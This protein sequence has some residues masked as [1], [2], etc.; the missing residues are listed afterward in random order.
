MAKQKKTASSRS[1]GAQRSTSSQPETKKKKAASRKAPRKTASQADTTSQDNPSPQAIVGIGASAGGLTTLKRFFANVAADTGLAYVVVMH[2]SPEYKSHLAEL[3]QPH[4]P[5]PVQQVTQTTPL[6]PNRV[7]VI[8]PGANLNTIDTHLRLTKLEPRR[9]ERAPIDYFFRTLAQTHDGNSIAVVLTGSGSDGTL[10]IRDIKASGGVALAQDPNDAEFGDMPQSA[11]S[12][13]LVDMVLP[14]EDIP[15]AIIRFAKTDP[16]VPALREGEEPDAVVRQQLQKIFTLLKSRTSR[17]FSRYKR[18]TIL[19]RI[20]RR[21]QLNQIEELH[22]YL[23]LLRKNQTEVRT[24]ADDLLITV[25]NFFRDPEVHKRLKD[26]IIPQLFRRKSPD[27]DIR[28]WSVGCA[29]GEEAYTLAML[30]LEEASQHESIPRLQVFASDLHER[31]LA[32]AR[33]GIYPGDIATDV[34]PERLKRFFVKENGHYRMR[35][36]VREMVVFAPHNLLADP[37]FS[38]IDLICCRNLMIYLQRG[39]QRNVIDLFHYAIRGEGFLVL[40]SAETLDS[41]DLFRVEDKKCCIYRKRNITPPEPRLPVFPFLATTAGDPVEQVP[42]TEAVGS[43]RAIHQRMLQQ[44][45]PPSAL[46]NTEDRV[47]HLSELAGRFFLHPG[48]EPTTNIYKLVRPELRL[49]LRSVMQESREAGGTTRSTPISV[50]FNGDTSV[51]LMRAIPARSQQDT[52]CTLVIFEEREPRAFTDR[53][54]TENDHD[55]ADHSDGR[56]GDRELEAE[57]ELTRQRLQSLVEEYETSQEEMKA[58]NEEM[59]SANEELR[60][61]MEELETSKEELQ[62]MNE[63]LQTVNQ[64][65]R[66]RV[67]ELAQLSSDLNNLFAATDIATLYLDKD[68]RILRLTPKVH[69]L[70]S[71]QL[72]DRGRPISDFTHRFG[73]EDLVADAQR[74]IDKLIPIDRELQDDQGRWHMTRVLPYRSDE[75]RIEGVVITFVDITERKRSEDETREAKAYAESIVDTLHEPLLVLNPDL[76][77][78]SCNPAFYQWFQVK[79]EDTIGRRVYDLGNGQWDI[80]QLRT[81]LEEVLPESNTFSDYVVDHQFQ[82]IGRRV[83]LL[84]ARRLDHVQLILLG[85]RDITE[86]KLAEQALR[87]SKNQLRAMI[88]VEGV[89]VLIFNLEGTVVDAN[90]GFLHMFGYSRE[91]VESRLLTWRS[92][93]PPEY[94]DVS[95][96]QMA[97]LEETGKVGPYE[98]EYFRKNGSRSWI[99]FAGAR[100]ND[101]IVEYCIDVGDRKRAE[102]ALRISEARY[103]MLFNSMDQGFCVFEMLFDE[104]RHPVDYRFIEVNPAFEAHTGLKDA[105]GKSMRELEP[106]H[107]EFWFETYGKVAKTGQPVRFEYYAAA[108]GRHFEVYAFREGE[109]QHRHVA[110]LFSDISERKKSEADLRD[111]NKTLESQVTERTRVAENRASALRRL[112]EELT[113]TEHR[114]RKR[115]AKL[116]HDDLQQQLV[117]ARMLLGGLKDVP[118]ERWNDHVAKAD[119]MLKESQTLSRNLTKELSPPVLQV[120]SLGELV[121]WIAERFHETNGLDIE[122]SVEEEFHEV[123][124]PVRVFFFQAIREL[125][126]NIIKHVDSKHATIV[127]QRHEE[128]IRVRVEDGGGDFDVEA[129]EDSLHHPESFGLFQIQ[130]RLNALGGTMEIDHSQSGGACFRLMVPLR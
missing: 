105:V 49:E 10:G 90:D 97:H 36:E 63:E 64:E 8:P 81:L 47:V 121:R 94:H 120:G 24:L 14:V 39:A 28:V 71:V 102:E 87:E 5:M 29:T 18:S 2:L 91:D 130:E 31:S 32:R 35:K 78:R 43:Y 72:T 129:V 92:M 41:S 80:P 3:L 110:C 70:F 12:T 93:T 23:E 48:G 9:Q 113:Q 83:M 76:T 109:P 77:V 58:A 111:L 128:N 45:G 85:I 54:E 4:V 60:S 68:L 19:R 118:H 106:A 107:E 123:S 127:L 25:T 96:Q 100:V 30:L 73:S 53:Q 95:Q 101:H 44:F 86:Q 67:E 112:S 108:L 66:H 56:S 38:R 79:L 126:F 116:L 21:M 124:E 34:S 26:E 11:I 15:E 33:D 42:A 61:T 1:S 125:L 69:E 117:G 115:L 46:V 104:K 40:G 57:L 55:S 13:G 51:V 62:S 7:Y 99:L 82:S 52:G 50:K 27:D 37:P 75:D 74:V 114:E 103:R 20:Q 59:Q 119:E 6:E 122:V 17:D 98:K 16:N 88:D 22:E 65:N 84:N 89:G